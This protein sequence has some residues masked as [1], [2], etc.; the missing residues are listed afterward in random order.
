MMESASMNLLSQLPCD[1]SV[2]EEYKAVMCAITA[3]V[4]FTDPAQWDSLPKMPLKTV[5]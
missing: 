3:R 2:V 1:Q 5:L 4:A